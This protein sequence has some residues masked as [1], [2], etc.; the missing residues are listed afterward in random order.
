MEEAINLKKK[1]F[2]KND[3]SCNV[4]GRIEEF[5][6]CP[7]I[8]VWEFD[9]V[10]SKVTYVVLENHFNHC[11]KFSKSLVSRNDNI[12]ATKAAEDS[13]IDC[14]IEKTPSW[15]DIDD[16]V[17]AGLEKKKISY[18]KSEAEPHGYSL[19]TAAN[20]R[21]KLLSENQQKYKWEPN[22]H[23]QNE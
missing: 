17:D 16:V 8:K 10:T 14:L 4:C 21:S 9:D 22:I 2:K 1:R 20:L 15:K 18:A 7:G 6:S 13:T 19:E 11:Q 12:T 23:F 5:K 3:F